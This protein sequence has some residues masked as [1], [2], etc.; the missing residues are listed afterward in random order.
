MS[1]IRN[2]YSSSSSSSPHLVP[3]H[4]LLTSTSLSLLPLTQPVLRQNHLAEHP[5]FA[6]L[7]RT[8][9]VSRAIAS[10]HQRIS[11]GLCSK[12][13]DL[14]SEAELTKFVTEE[15]GWKVEA[16]I[17]VIEANEDNA[18]KGK[19]ISEVVELGRESFRLSASMRT[20][21]G[22]RTRVVSRDLS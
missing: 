1:P 15:L 19:T 7:V 14:K 11:V 22:P 3:L 12:W 9:V 2:P 21:A 17:V 18:V 5:L 8:L 6:L 20:T 4:S 10:T 16:G 13:F